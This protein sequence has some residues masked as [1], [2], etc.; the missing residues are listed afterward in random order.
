MPPSSVTLVIPDGERRGGEA[1]VAAAALDDEPVGRV[2]LIDRDQ[3]RKPE[4][5]IEGADPE[6]VD[7]VGAAGAVHGHRIGWAS[8][9]EPPIVPARLTVTWVTSVPVRS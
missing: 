6:H 5:R 3:G 8:P 7:G 1:V 2:G 4:H 9:A